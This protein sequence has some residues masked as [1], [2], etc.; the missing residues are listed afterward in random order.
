MSKFLLTFELDKEFEQIDVHFDEVGLEQ[1]I[2]ILQNLRGVSDHDHMMTPSWGGDQLSD[3][4][5][6]DQTKLINKVTLHKW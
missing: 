4:P 2:L 3:E 5:Q 1:L 6:S